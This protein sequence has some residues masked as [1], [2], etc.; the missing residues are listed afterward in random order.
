MNGFPDRIE[1]DEILLRP[2]ATGDISAIKRHLGDPEIARWMAAAR[3]PFG[4]AEAEEILAIS[5][6][7]SR[8]IRVLE[9]H[10]AIVGC[11][12]LSPDVWFWVGPASQGQGLMSRA[13]RAAIAAHFACL[14]PPLIATCRDDNQPSQALLSTLGFSRMPSGRCMFFESE[15][16]AMPCHDHVMTPEQWFKL[17]PP[18]QRHGSLTLRPAAQKDAPTLTLMLPRSGSDDSGIWPLPEAL[19]G[20]IEKH[21]CRAPGRGL[22]VMEDEHRRVIGMLLL[23]VRGINSGVLYLAKEDSDRFDRE[24]SAILHG[25][26]T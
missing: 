24:L 25:T 26:A 22:F 16:R 5:Q 12:C 3:Q 21:R 10:G 7:P 11:I 23:Q 19:S 8:R 15:G 17:H 2:M 18:V 1:T 20:F 14:E 4:Q 9:K 6:D 13:L